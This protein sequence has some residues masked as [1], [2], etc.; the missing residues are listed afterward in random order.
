M[1]VVVLV[2][3]E[4]LAIATATSQALLLGSQIVG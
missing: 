1:T 3:P 4:N 2:V